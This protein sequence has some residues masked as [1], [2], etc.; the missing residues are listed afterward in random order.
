MSV[1]RLY[2]LWRGTKMLARFGGHISADAMHV[3]FGLLGFFAFLYLF[4]H[5]KK[6]AIYAWIAV[7]ACQ[8]LNEMTDI[9]FDLQKLGT[10][11]E[12]NTIKDSTLTLLWPSIFT[13]YLMNRRE[14]HR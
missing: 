12:W 3:N 7:F 4:R 5:S 8:F 13:V 6:A 2:E 10:V 11:K 14:K 1:D 9:F